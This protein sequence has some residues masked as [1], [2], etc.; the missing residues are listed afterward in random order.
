MNK[1][2]L[3]AGSTL[4]AAAGL[5]VTTGVNGHL[6][7]GAS[8]VERANKISAAPQHRIPMPTFVVVGKITPDDSFTLGDPRPQYVPREWIDELN[9]WR[10]DDG[11][12]FALNWDED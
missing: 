10:S 4:V 1:H 8:L 11:A 9:S 5:A 7:S 3:V 12:P 6:P 2:S